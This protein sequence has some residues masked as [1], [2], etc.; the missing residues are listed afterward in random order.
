MHTRADEVVAL[1]R[2]PHG[3]S[4]VLPTEKRRTW[5]VGSDPRCDLVLDDPSVAP[6]HCYLEFDGDHIHTFPCTTCL[7]RPRVNGAAVDEADLR[8]GDVL[9]LGHISLVACSTT[10]QRAKIVARDFLEFLQGS[11]AAYGSLRAAADTLR[12]PYSTLRG[13][14]KKQRGRTA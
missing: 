11:V 13:W 4:Y 8:P 5:A 3:P 12:L 14:I 7:D 9:T 1:R 6:F 2:L 10:D